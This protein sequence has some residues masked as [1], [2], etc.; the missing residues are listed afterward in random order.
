MGFTVLSRVSGAEFGMLVVERIAEIRR[1][2][3]VH[4]KPGASAAFV[5]LSFEPGEAYQFDWSHE[6]VLIDGITMTV[7]V[8]H[9]RLCHC[10]APGSMDNGLHYA[11]SLRLAAIQRS[12]AATGLMRPFFSTS[13]SVL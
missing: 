3:F 6:V 11:A 2:H 1:A 7:K 9:M 5:P 8:A 10:T 4:G 13:H 12:R